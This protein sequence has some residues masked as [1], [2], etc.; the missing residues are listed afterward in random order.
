MPRSSKPLSLIKGRKIRTTRL[1]GCGRFVLG[2][3]SQAVTDGAVSV[4]F[5]ANTTETEEINVPNMAGDRCVFEPSVTSLAGYSLEIV[6]CAVDFEV[7][8]MI[9]GQTLVFDFLG[10]VIG[11][12][13]DTK[14]DVSD[15]GFALE[16]WAGAPVGDVCDDPNAQ[17]SFGYLLLPRLEGGYLSDFTI[18]NGAIN[19]TLTGAS[20]REGNQW[21]FGPYNVMLDEN[22]DPS[23]LS[24]AVSKTA[25]LRLQETS[26]A[27]PESFV[28]ARP[29]LN[30]ALPAFTNI[31]A[32]EGATDME[33]DFTLT[34]VSTGPVWWEFGDGGWDYVVAPG[35]TDHLY[36]TPGTYTVRATQNGQDWFSKT[37][38]VP[39]P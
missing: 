15:M 30:T 29:L 13:V 36:T 38:T 20:T 7:F 33:V 26:L 25:A 14:V 19:F 11:L 2:E 39:F 18:E 6:F 35:A 8:E 24:Q 37:V 22:G 28:G 12:E 27:P 1:D 23:V 32:V 3:Y 31:T 4:A 21:G 9:T 10:N 17:G 34:A 5:T 16:V